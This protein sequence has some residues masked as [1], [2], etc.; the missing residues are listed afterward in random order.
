MVALDPLLIEI[1]LGHNCSK[2]SRNVLLPHALTGEPIFRIA[3]WSHNCG[4]DGGFIK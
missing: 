1:G 3:E 4:T 2:I